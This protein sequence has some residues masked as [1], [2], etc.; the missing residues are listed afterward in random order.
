MKRW[1]SNI[2]DEFE[3]KGLTHLAQIVV[4]EQSRKMKLSYITKSEHEGND[5]NLPDSEVLTLPSPITIVKHIVEA[6]KDV[7]AVPRKQQLSVWQLNPKWLATTT[8]K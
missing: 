4:Q 5:K 2:T 7:E 1:A 6:K 3:D 8:N